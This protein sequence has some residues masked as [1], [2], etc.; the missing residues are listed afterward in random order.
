MNKLIVGL[1]LAALAFTFIMFVPHEWLFSQGVESDFY[2]TY[3][4]QA[5]EIARRFNPSDT[6][7][8]AHFDDH[9]WSYHGEAYPTMLYLVGLLFPQ[10]QPVR[11]YHFFHAARIISAVSASSLF[12]LIVLV[13]GV[14]Y[15]LVIS[16]LMAMIF[17]LAQY[18][19]SVGTDMI[20]AVL[21]LWAG[22]FC[23]KGKW[24]ALVV[25]I[26][27]MLCI[28]IRH[29]YLFIA[30][31]LACWLWITDRKFL[32]FFLLPVTLFVLFS[33][34]SWN[35]YCTVPHKYLMTD[36]DFDKFPPQMFEQADMD[37]V[38]NYYTLGNDI[39]AKYYPSIFSVVKAAGWRMPKIFFKDF[40]WSIFYISSELALLLAGLLF[41]P[42]NSIWKY[43]LAAVGLHLLAVNLFGVYTERYFIFDIIIL[44]SLL[45]YGLL[46]ATKSKKLLLVLLIFIIVISGKSFATR[47]DRSLRYDS[48]NMNYQEYSGLFETLG[49]PIPKILSVRSQVAFMNNW[50]WQMWPKE[51]H[52]LHAYCMRYGVDLLLYGGFEK[53]TRS[54]WTQ[55]LQ[56]IKL[57]RPEFIA[58]AANP[59][60]ILYLVNNAH[61]ADT[62][63]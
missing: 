2:T 32:A 54:E 33:Y 11:G 36:G 24:W 22:Y 12:L 30:P 37:T 42:K 14:E 34:G 58:L 57:A 16:V 9:A 21:A 40:L 38:E 60:G 48:N 25:G 13:F 23:Y 20:A 3:I 62:T 10:N 35:T 5:Q 55:K 46:Q 27:L 47:F 63:R 56:D 15:G 53:M 45:S 26:V 50:D 61:P 41:L 29:E 43:V 59:Y 39:S 51:L 17:P 28:G 8:Y 6:T 52:D 18:S 4:P 49:K 19:Y 44:G 1:G 31:V 7:H